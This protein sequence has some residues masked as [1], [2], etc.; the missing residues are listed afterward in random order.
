MGVLR[1]VSCVTR[2][3]SFSVSTFRETERSPRS[4][5]I[6]FFFI[7]RDCK[8][9]PIHFTHKKEQGYPT[10][11]GTIFALVKMEDLFNFFM[12]HHNKQGKRFCKFCFMDPFLFFSFWNP[13]SKLNRPSNSA[14]PKI[15]PDHIEFFSRLFLFYQCI[16]NLSVILL[17]KIN[18][19]DFLNIHDFFRLLL[20]I[21]RN[22]KI[23][24]Q[25]NF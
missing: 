23:L 9:Q 8:N 11:S 10:K 19:L 5:T 16:N 7:H 22:I 12:Q 18:V 1:K 14:R 3:R 4:Y 2:G 24:I 15:V 13:F 21:S 6:Y 25:S 17:H 20:S